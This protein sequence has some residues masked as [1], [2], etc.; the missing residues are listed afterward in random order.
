MNNLTLSQNGEYRLEVWREQGILEIPDVRR[1]RKEKKASRSVHLIVC[2]E[3]DEES[4]EI[5]H[6]GLVTLCGMD[7]TPGSS[8]RLYRS[9]SQRKT[10]LVL[11]SNS[12]LEPLTEDLRGRLQVDLNTLQVT[13]SGVL[14][15]DRDSRFY[16]ATWRE[17]Q[18]QNVNYINLE[19]NYNAKY[20]FAYPYGKEIEKAYKMYHCQQYCTS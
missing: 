6:G 1:K 5:V 20:V 19:K 7:S 14:K 15:T 12:S 8:L 3:G 2:A 10:L 9:R 4:L 16:G 11:D 17:D 13:L 18:C